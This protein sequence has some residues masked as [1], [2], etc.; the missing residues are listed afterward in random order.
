MLYQIGTDSVLDVGEDIGRA[1]SEVIGGAF[2]KLTRAGNASGGLYQ[3]ILDAHDYG[4]DGAQCG[5]SAE[6]HFDAAGGNV[7]GVHR[8]RD[9]SR[10]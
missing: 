6:F 4:L 10:G 2:A 5:N 3:N 9:G 8:G 1:V 7:P